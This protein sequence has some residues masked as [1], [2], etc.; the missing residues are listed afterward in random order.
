MF[1]DF[2][3]MPVP[4]HVAAQS[5]SPTGLQ[6]NRTLLCQAYHLDKVTSTW[7]MQQNSQAMQWKTNVIPQLIQIYLANCTETES[8]RV[9]LS[10]KPVHKC[11]CNRVVLKVELIT[12][13]HKFPALSNR[14]LAHPCHIR[15]LTAD[16]VSLQVLPC[17]HPTI[18]HRLL[19][20][21]ACVPNACLQHQPPRACDYSITPH[22]TECNRVVQLSSRVSLDPWVSIGGEGMDFRAVPVR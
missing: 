1:E 22:G 11:Q 20:L 17:Q 19:P 9:P 21:C 2:T 6:D 8:G 14:I 7:N 16:L 18:G 12:W 5:S 15:V 3:H 13:D 10:T 4:L